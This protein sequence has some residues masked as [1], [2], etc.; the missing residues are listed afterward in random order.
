M[1]AC[2][3]LLFSLVNL[4]FVDKT[5]PR[6]GGRRPLMGTTATIR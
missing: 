6:E 2:P 4:R 1:T 3:F 5:V